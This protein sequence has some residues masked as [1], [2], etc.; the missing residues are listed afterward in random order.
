M[1]HDRKAVVSWESL[2][3]I[4]TQLILFQRVC[5]LRLEK[6]TEQANEPKGILVRPG[7]DSDMANLPRKKVRFSSPKVAHCHSAEKQ[8][9]PKLASP[10]GRSPLG[11]P[12]NKYPFY[13]F[14]ISFPIQ[15]SA[16]IVAEYRAKKA[17]QAT[18]E[19]ITQEA[20]GL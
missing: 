11:S 1:F 8:E 10:L 9:S 2:A 18:R 12:Y 16:K 13:P 17:A 4:D 15:S 6:S 7:D 14:D 3:Y 19:R 20:Q 5:Q